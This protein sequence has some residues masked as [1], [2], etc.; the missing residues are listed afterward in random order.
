MAGKKKEDEI[1]KEEILDVPIDFKTL[2]AIVNLYG[3][4]LLD[5]NVRT[6]EQLKHLASKT[7]QNFF[8][9]PL[10]AQLDV[11]RSY[12]VR[13][14]FGTKK[15]KKGCFVFQM[16]KGGTQQIKEYKPE[17]YKD[18]QNTP[19]RVRSRTI[20]RLAQENPIP[21]L[22]TKIKQLF[23]SY[24]YHLLKSEPIN[25]RLKN[26]YFRRYIKERDLICVYRL[27]DNIEGLEPDPSQDIFYA[28][29]DYAPKTT[30]AF[31]YE[32]RDVEY[33][34]AVNSRND[35]I[36]NVLKIVWENE[37]DEVQG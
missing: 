27:R 24:P 20:M 13:G 4:G 2:E 34:Y 8:K 25:L 10:R 37:I 14:N 23:I 33:Y 5:I 36:S 7:L 9:L 1:K 17:I 22:K 15:N 3:G 12:D 18:E 31:Q 32:D 28:E 16:A 29:K 30:I 21:D 6:P 11:L 19:L 35:E 26:F